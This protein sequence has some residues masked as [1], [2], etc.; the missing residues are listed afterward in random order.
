MEFLLY[1][2]AVQC[3][4]DGSCVKFGQRNGEKNFK[5]DLCMK[6]PCQKFSRYFLTMNKNIATLMCVL[7]ILW[8]CRTMVYQNPLLE[9]I[10]TT[11][12]VIGKGCTGER[13]HLRTQKP[14]IPKSQMRTV[15]NFSYIGDAVH[16]GFIPHGKRIN[17]NYYLEMLKV[18]AY[19]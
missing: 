16:F 17:Q 3:G 10:R 15:L 11:L 18:F 19:L 1:R 13:R 7:I 5:G 9:M 2:K 6:C 12:K 14:L 8:S 4:R